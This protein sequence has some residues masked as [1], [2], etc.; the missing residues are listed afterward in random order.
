VAAYSAYPGAILNVLEALGLIKFE[1]PQPRQPVTHWVP[2]IGTMTMG[3][4]ADGDRKVKREAICREV[5][6]IHTLRQ[7]GWTVTR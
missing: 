2:I 7:A 5:D 3:D 1:E 4:R 6:L